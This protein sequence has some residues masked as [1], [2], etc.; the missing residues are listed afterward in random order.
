MKF[1]LSCLLFNR[2]AGNVY[3]CKKSL[4]FRARSNMFNILCKLGFNFF[5]PN[6]CQRMF[7]DNMIFV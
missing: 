6:D 1:I 4:N 3:L 5:T 2:K 7:D